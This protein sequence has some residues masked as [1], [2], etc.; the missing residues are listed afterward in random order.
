MLAGHY[1][2]GRAVVEMSGYAA[3]TSGTKF[4]R[5]RVS[6]Y[7]NA[8]SFERVCVLVGERREGDEERLQ[9]VESVQMRRAR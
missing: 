2:V 9:V 4:K 3:G 1:A 6:V 7:G 8:N 5:G